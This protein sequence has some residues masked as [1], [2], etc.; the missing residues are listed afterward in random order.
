MWTKLTACCLLFGAAL[1]AADSGPV[2]LKNSRPELFITSEENGIWKA[3]NQVPSHFCTLEFQVDCPWRPELELRFEYRNIFTAGDK[4]A[5]TGVNFFDESKRS[6]FTRLPVSA[7]WTEATIPFARLRP[8]KDGSFRT[9]DRF[10]RLTIYSRIASDDVPGKV[11]IEVRNIRFTVDPEYNPYNQGGITLLARKNM[12]TSP[13]KDGVWETANE[14]PSRFCT[15]PLQIHCAFRPDLLLRFEYRNLPGENAHL[16]Y[17]GVNLYDNRKR[18]AFT[19]FPVSAEWKQAEVSFSRLRPIQGGVFGDN[20][21]FIQLDIYSRIANSDAPGKATIQVRNIQFAVNPEYN[22]LDGVRV[23]YSAQPMFNWKQGPR[24]AGYRLEFSQDPALPSDATQQVELT[25]NFFVPSEF[26]KPGLWHYRVTAL[27]ENREIVRDKLFIPERSH[28]WRRPPFDFAKLATTPHPRLLP[29]ARYYAEISGDNQ[30]KAAEKL[31]KFTVPPNP[32]PY[33]EGADPNIRAWVEWYGKIA[34]G[35]ISTTGKKLATVGQAAMLTGRHDLKQKAREL[36][37][38]VSRTW[39]PESGSQMKRADLQAANLLMGMGYCFDA[40]YDLMTP[41]ERTEV[42]RAIETRGRQFWVDANPFRSNESQNHPWDRA[43]ALAFAAVTLAENP[44]SREWFDFVADLYATRFLP[45]LG[46][47]GENNEGLAYWSYGLG[48][49]IRYVDL[50]KSVAGM[51]YYQQPW[52]AKT[53]RFPLYCAPTDGFWISFADNGKPNHSNLGPV[54]REFTRRLAR[55][56]GDPIALWYAGFPRDGELLA[57]PPTCI[58]QSMIYPHIGLAVFNTFLPDGRENVAVGFHSGKFFAGHQHADQ[59]AFVINAYGDKLAIDGGYY[60]WYG[61]KHFKAYSVHTQAH[62]TI[63]VN[64]E[65]Q[66][67]NTK[68]A[69]GKLT[70]TFDS[71]GFGYAAGDA[72]APKI[73][74]RKLSKFNRRLLF[75]KPSMVIIFDELA[76]PEPATFRWQLLSHTE[77]MDDTRADGSCF[78][79]IR[80][81]ARLDGRMLLPTNSAMHVEKAYSVDPVQGYSVDAIPH[82][83]PEWRIFTENTA[84]AQTTEF[85][86]AMHITRSEEHTGLPEYRLLQSHQAVGVQTRDAED[87]ILVLFNRRPGQPFS[88]ENIT[89]DAETAALRLAPD[90]T[91]RDAMISG[92]T[93]LRFRDQELLHLSTPGAAA[94]QKSQS[95]ISEKVRLLTLN[96]TPVELERHTIPQA[97]GRHTTLYTGLLEIPADAR[98]ELTVDGNDERPVHY[99]ISD[100][101]AR[102]TGTLIGSSTTIFLNQGSYLFNLSTAGNLQQ[103][104]VRTSNAGRAQGIMHP[105]DYQLPRDALLVEAE[106]P[107]PATRS[108]VDIAERTSASGGKATINWSNAGQAAQWIFQV[109]EA[110]R[111]RL[112]LRTATTYPRIFREITMDGKPP[113]ADLGTL[114]WGNTGG[115]GYTPDEWR[116]VELPCDLTLSAGE[117]RLGIRTLSGSANL[118]CFALIKVSDPRP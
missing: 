103:I 116:W 80:P 95:V 30:E 26:L 84:P 63:L 43:Q 53:A 37:L 73:Y 28:H 57:Q 94:L 34:G 82:P 108:A 8:G 112:L 45:S 48:L 29:L 66:S 75:V 44:E 65:G 109:P 33:R 74:N 56:T 51:N 99:V 76:A 23:S 20:D 2:E 102:H 117:H 81:L 88:L 15:L 104:A 39:D 106:N 98:L 111:Y 36:V 40:A 70:A 31:L 60:D 61:S 18:S 92:G 46:F 105:T 91:V 4:I 41:E 27:P 59:N 54:N 77:K 6:T 97:N 22:P 42:S 90:G 5:Y 24:A 113:S 7:D 83:Q 32:E 93:M 12:T 67:W 52:L 35:V 96:G 55:Q 64:G 69:D 58:P 89:T 86:A 110:G 107:T 114:Q 21:H 49:A 79:V 11:A 118:D 47:D 115:F 62:N 9:S 13:R 100:R 101:S 19:Q 50:V 71:P 68:D 78:S 85:L 14:T 3:A 1:H 17:T 72:S 25:R 38:A 87:R 16:A 10:R